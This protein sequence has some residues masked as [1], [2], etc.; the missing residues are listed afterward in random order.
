ESITS[1]FVI[2]EATMGYD[3]NVLI[4]AAF[5]KLTPKNL[6]VPFYSVQTAD[7]SDWI[8]TGA[9]AN[10]PGWRSVLNRLGELAQ[11]PLA[12]LAEVLEDGT[13]IAKIEFAKTHP[14]DPF[15]IR[16]IAESKLAKRRQF[17]DA[18]ADARH[19][20]DQHVSEINCDLDLAAEGFQSK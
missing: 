14:A 7:L 20:I 19:T 13:K 9:K 5:D 1:R 17:D 3:R 18:M 6:R 2:A 11:R 12:Q 16:F 10:H 15:T 8:E 4:A